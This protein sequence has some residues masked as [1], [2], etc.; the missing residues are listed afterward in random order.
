[1]IENDALATTTLVLCATFQPNTPPCDV[2]HSA[3]PAVEVT[4][5]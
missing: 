1:M 2:K 4:A 3:A 5:T